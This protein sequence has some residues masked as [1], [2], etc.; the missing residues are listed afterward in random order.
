MELVERSIRAACSLEGVRRWMLG[1]VSSGTQKNTTCISEGPVP[2][3]V[4]SY[5]VLGI[6]DETEFTK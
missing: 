4:A 2:A 5:C 1:N 6:A 3:C